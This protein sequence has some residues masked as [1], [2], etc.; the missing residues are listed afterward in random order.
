MKKNNINNNNNNKYNN[1]PIIFITNNTKYKNILNKSGI[2]LDKNHQI[3]AKIIYKNNED[4]YIG[5]GIYAYTF[6]SYKEYDSKITWTCVPIT[7]IPKNEFEDNKTPNQILKFNNKDINKEFIIKKR[8]SICPSVNDEVIIKLNENNLNM[9]IYK[10]PAYITDIINYLKKNASDEGLKCKVLTYNM[11]DPPSKTEQ[12]DAE[13]NTIGFINSIPGSIIFG[14]GKWNKFKVP[15]N[16]QYNQYELLTHNLFPLN[17]LSKIDEN[18]SFIFS[19]NNKDLF[20]FNF[21]ILK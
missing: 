17:D 1:M 15:Y 7:H 18:N 8:N 3:E 12:F 13:G 2:I 6:P 21:Y 5:F 4:I 19:I 9:N 14:T 16:K 20:Y 11:W 10:P